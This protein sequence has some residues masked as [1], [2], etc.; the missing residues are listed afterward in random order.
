MPIDFE[1]I[2]KQINEG[3]CIVDKNQL[4]KWLKD[5]DNIEQFKKQVTGL[6]KANDKLKAENEKIKKKCEETERKMRC[7]QAEI[8]AVKNIASREFSDNA[9]MRRKLRKMK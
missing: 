8:A 7:V 6:Q 9:K 2:K 1:N 4:L 3:V 5:V